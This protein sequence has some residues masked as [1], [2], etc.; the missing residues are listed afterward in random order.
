VGAARQLPEAAPSLAPILD[1]LRAN[2]ATGCLRV[3]S[4]SRQANLYLLFGH[5][6]HAEG[7]AGTGDA[8]LAEA[9][10]WSP[11]TAQLDTRAKLPETETIAEIQTMVVDAPQVSK[12][13]LLDQYASA[14][15]VET[16]DASRLVIPLSTA[17]RLL[18]GGAGGLMVVGA[19]FLWTSYSTVF[20][21]VL[22]GFLGF[23]GIILVWWAM[24]WKLILT[25]TGFEVVG[26]LTR[27]RRR[28]A[29]VAAFETDVSTWGR[30]PVP[31]VHFRD[32][33]SFMVGSMQ[34]KGKW[35]WALGTLGNS[36]PPRGMSAAEQVKLLEEW[37][38][39]YSP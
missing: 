8:A 17:E 9:R 23:L 16:T 37:R 27:K 10:A 18:R 34:S 6:Y 3:T 35:R 2:R 36:F 13:A 4:G 28:W 25:P 14:P 19:L 20:A 12:Q 39:R 26:M 15:P 31:V 33:Q 21:E 32:S 22:A 5:V 30:R 29:D 7:P 38:A 24:T 1:A 11:V